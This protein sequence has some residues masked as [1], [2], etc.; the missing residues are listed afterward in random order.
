[1]NP[2]ALVYAT[3]EG[4]SRRIAEYM[5]DRF[6]THGVAIELHDARRLPRDFTLARFGSAVL[7]A[8]VHGGAHEVEMANFV[9]RHATALGAIPS[10]FLSVSLSE[11]GA[12]DPHRPQDVR[13][14]SSQD[15][16]RMMTDFFRRTGWTPTLSLPVAGALAYTKYNPLTRFVL[17]RIAKKAGGSTDTSCDHEYTDWAAIDGFID[18]LVAKLQADSDTSVHRA[19]TAAR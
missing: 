12:E 14:R 10:A 6:R 3:R 4:Q 5:A 13:E 7:I 19:A 11:A 1:M 18:R 16:Q 9:R 8:S 2:L 15:A 17:K